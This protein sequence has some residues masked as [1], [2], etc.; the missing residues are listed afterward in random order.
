MRKQRKQTERLGT[1]KV[2]DF[3]LRH[4]EQ[5]FGGTKILNLEPADFEQSLN[6]FKNLYFDKSEGRVI[7]KVDGHVRVDILDGYAPFCKLLV[8]ENV[9]DAKAGAIPFEL[10]HYPFIRSGYSSRKKG[11]WP[12]LSRWLELPFGKPVAKYTVTVLYS[13][14]QMDKEALIDYDKTLAK[15]GVDAIGLEKP[16][17]FGADWGVVAILGQMTPREEPMKPITMMR[18]YMDLSMGGSGMKLPVPPVKPNLTEE[19]ELMNKY[20]QAVVKYQ[21]E[22]KEIEDRFERSVKFWETHMTVK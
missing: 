13:K 17:L 15:G 16:E 22:M 10:G 1:I 5:D 18:N 2:S 19:S 8:M 12:V 9:T 3:A 7:D 11:E 20:N 14:S 21:T 4:F 6:N